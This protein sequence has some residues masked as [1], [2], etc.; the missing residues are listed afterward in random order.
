[1]LYVNNNFAINTYFIPV[2]GIIPALP[3]SENTLRSAIRRVCEMWWE[4]GL[5]GKEQLGKTAFIML[6][7]K[8]L[9]KA[10]M[11]CRSYIEF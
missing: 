2:V 8:S 5:E 11:V 3:E 7:K 1:M 10:A 9:S 6:L 4:K